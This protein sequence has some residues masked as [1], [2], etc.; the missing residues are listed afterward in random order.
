MT[1]IV[2]S[3]ERPQGVDSA[4][5]ARQ[6]RRYAVVAGDPDWGDPGV[7]AIPGTPA[8]W[9]EK[10]RD[11]VGLMHA[12]WVSMLMTRYAIY[13]GLVGRTLQATSDG[14]ITISPAM[15]KDTVPWNQFSNDAFRSSAVFTITKK[16][17]TPSFS[18][19]AGPPQWG[20]TC[21]ASRA[22]LSVVPHSKRIGMA[23]PIADKTDRVEWWRATCQYCYA[24]TGYYQRASK[25]ASS[26]VLYLWTRQALR[27]GEFVPYMA[28]AISNLNYHL[29]GWK[30]KGW[31]A[32]PTGERYFRIH[33]SGDFFSAEYIRAWRAIADALPSIRFWA[34]TRLQYYPGYVRT[35]NEVNRSARNLI[36]RPST[37]HAEQQTMQPG[38]GVGKHLSRNAWAGGS[39]VCHKDDVAH[40]KAQGLFRYNC[41][42][43]D[44]TESEKHTCRHAGCRACWDSPRKTINYALHGPGAK[45]GGFN[46]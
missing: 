38:E 8:E 41:P 3:P 39:T 10:I 9:N 11:A 18:L 45:K 23:K 20:G 44:A 1:A 16:M 43:Y 22:G 35:I 34:P 28:E 5:L 14:R 21:P 32:E 29:D 37:F 31:P 27:T 40:F 6:T 19:P 13:R 2:P 33:D 25:Q 36:I 30:A 4:Y 42:A 46:E 15:P 12:E 26:E 24:A 7:I 17:A